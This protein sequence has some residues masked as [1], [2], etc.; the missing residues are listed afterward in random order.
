MPFKIK[1]CAICGVEFQ[2]RS[3]A[4]KVCDGC[5]PEWQRRHYHELH[6]ARY[7]Q[8]GTYK[9]EMPK[10]KD[11]PSYKNGFGIF[12]KIAFDNLPNECSRCGSTVNLCVHHKDRNRKHNEVCNLEIVCKSC[13]QK[14]HDAAAHLFNEVTRQKA[15]EASKAYALSR[16][17][18]VRDEKGRFKKKDTFKA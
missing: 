16:T 10:G 17:D 7:K 5:R 13:H 11:S 18:L 9:W 3:G 6:V 15:V 4:A 2:P 12:Q 8:K 1:M 14:E